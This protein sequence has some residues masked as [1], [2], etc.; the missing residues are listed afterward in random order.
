MSIKY[1]LQPN[2]I[3]PDPNDQSARVQPNDVYEEEDLIDVMLKRG[4]SATKPDIIGILN[5][6][7]DVTSDLVAEG[8]NVNTRL[9][10]FKPSIVGV[11]KNP[12]DTFDRTRHT[13]KATISSGI[14]LTKKMAAASVEKIT[15]TAPNPSLIDFL[16]INTQIS[17]S[18]LTPGGIGQIIGSELKFD[19][20]KLTEG[21]FFVDATG[22]S[23]K[24]SVI[25]SRTDGK[26][27][28][29]IP[30]GLAVGNYTLEVR[31]G[32]GVAGNIRVGTLNDTLQ[33]V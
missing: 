12:L 11:F 27:M 33:V 20:S 7:Y 17:N 6:Y 28:F 31:K 22:V 23:T 10:N 25:A 26:L 9:S 16:D 30:S 14:L 32:Y 15:Q 29:G 5:L 8:A 1:Y 21:I 24:V 2:L 18:K 3:T 4:T 13:I 19:V